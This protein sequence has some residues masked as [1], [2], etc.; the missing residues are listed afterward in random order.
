M[1][2]CQFKWFVKALNGNLDQVKALKQIYLC[3]EDKQKSGVILKALSGELSK[4]D[5]HEYHFEHLMTAYLLHVYTPVLPGRP[6][7]NMEDCQFQNLNKYLDL[8]ILFSVV[9]PAS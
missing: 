9:S 1:E 6:P 3:I 2:D 4:N 8:L 5:W 7:L